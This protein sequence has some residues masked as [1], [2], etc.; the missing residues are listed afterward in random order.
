MYIPQ[1]DEFVLYNYSGRPLMAQCV[2]INGGKAAISFQW[3]TEDKTKWVPFTK[4]TPADIPPAVDVEGAP[5]DPQ[6]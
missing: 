4:L 6:D 3:G 5:D 1:V 2:A